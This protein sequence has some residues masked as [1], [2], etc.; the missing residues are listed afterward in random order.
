M[1][2]GKRYVHN[3]YKTDS[4]PVIPLSHFLQEPL[5]IE[6]YSFLGGGS[7]PADMALIKQLA[8][9]VDHCKYF[10][11][12]T[13]RG[14]SVA[15]IASSAEICYTLDLPDHMRNKIHNDVDYMESSDFFSKNTAN[16][17]HLMGDSRT[18]DFGSLNLKFDLIFIDGDHHYESIVNDTQKIL[19]NLY[20][21][22][23]HNC[24]A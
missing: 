22:T 7:S 18:F 11:I 12:G 10:E 5:T 21:R 16:I 1:R 14:E 24:M 2:N 3:K 15:N 4:L 19:E 6:P 23:N 8:L 20:P 17:N 13:W 9:K